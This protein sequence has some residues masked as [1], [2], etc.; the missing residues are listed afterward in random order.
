MA[1]RRRRLAYVAKNVGAIAN[2]VFGPVKLSGE[3]YQKSSIYSKKFGPR[4]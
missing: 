3:L 1:Y 2:R 4:I